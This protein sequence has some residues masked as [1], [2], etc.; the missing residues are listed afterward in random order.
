[1]FNVLT[2]VRHQSESVTF[3]PSENQLNSDY[4]VNTVMGAFFFFTSERVIHFILTQVTVLIH[5]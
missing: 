2:T 5:G 1:M 3:N 4:L